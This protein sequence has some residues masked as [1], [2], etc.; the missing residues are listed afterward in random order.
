MKIL[1]YTL[2]LIPSLGFSQVQELSS[3][4][5]TYPVKI[6]LKDDELFCFKK[7]QAQRIYYDYNKLL[8]YKEQVANKDSM[9]TSLNSEVKILNDVKLIDEKLIE[10]QK[11]K[12]SLYEDIIKEKNRQI[13]L[14][15]RENMISKLEHKSHLWNGVAI[16]G[17][18]GLIIG[19]IIGSK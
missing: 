10:V 4:D 13:G 16:A 14:S 11:N 12:L 9:I 6:F 8:G 2:I 1:L 15:N 7:A 5:T 3:A 18:L 19:F 17:G